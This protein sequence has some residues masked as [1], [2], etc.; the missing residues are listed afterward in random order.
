[1]SSALACAGVSTSGATLEW[2][3]AGIGSSFE[4]GRRNRK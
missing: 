2:S 4:H 1:L 3:L